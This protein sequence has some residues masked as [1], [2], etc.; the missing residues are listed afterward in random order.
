MTFTLNLHWF[1]IEL[2]VTQEYVTPRQIRKQVQ[3]VL[4]ETGSKL[5]AIRVHR[6]LTGSKTSLHE[7][8]DFVCS[9]PQRPKP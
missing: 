7:S 5:D 8:K 9:L 3:K 6:Q 2:T 1:K 4:W